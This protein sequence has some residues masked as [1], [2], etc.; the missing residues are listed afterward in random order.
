MHG[1]RKM[2]N[3]IQLGYQKAKICSV[4]VAIILLFWVP[5]ATAEPLT[6]NTNIANVR[7]GPGTKYDVIWKVEKYHPVNIV[8]KAGKWYRFKDFEGDEG[9]LHNSLLAKIPAVITTKDKCNVRSGAGTNF[10]IVFTVD[11]GIPFKVLKRK[12]K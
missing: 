8:E 12:G 4:A 5:Y 9:W 3:Y 1:I 6:V 7:S 11:K 2:N 10:E